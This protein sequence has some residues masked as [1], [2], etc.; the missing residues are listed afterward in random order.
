[1]TNP[2]RLHRRSVLRGAGGIAIALPWLEAMAPER[3]SHAATALPRRFLSVYNPGGTILER[4]TP[5]GT[6]EA[7]ALSPIL[8][9]YA[10]VKDR[11]LVLS[12]IDIKSADGGGSQYSRGMAAWLTGTA[13]KHAD[14]SRDAFATGPSVDQVLA[15][16]IAATRPRSSLNLGV[17][18]GTGLCMGQVHSMDI[19]SYGTDAAVTPIAPLIDPVAIWN[20]LFG[21]NAATLTWER[22]ILDAVDRRYARLAARLGAADRQRLEQ[23]LTSFRELEQR[24]AATGGLHRSACSA[25]ALPDTSACDP[26]SGL[27]TSGGADA[28]TDALI[29]LVGKLMMDMMLMALACDITAV[30]TLQWSDAEAG[31]PSGSVLGNALRARGRSGAVDVFAP[32]PLTTRAPGR[33]RPPPPP[34]PALAPVPVNLRSGSDSSY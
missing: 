7:F 9:P 30:G 34:L 33:L 3:A 12:G 28:E 24:L 15:A 21:T 20:Q 26:A 10:T 6:E 22:S 8:S 19:V 11:V 31:A 5:T 18:W 14:F 13:A 25:P 27:T 16:R 23:H 29:P 2:F 17:R 4:W 1:M 32:H